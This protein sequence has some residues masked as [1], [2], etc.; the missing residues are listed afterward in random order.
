MLKGYSKRD[1]EFARRWFKK[2]K[3]VKVLGGKCSKCG[4]DNIVCLEFHHLDSKEKDFCVAKM[5]DRSAP[6]PEIEE[7][8]KKCI[9]LC[10][11]CH[12]EFH[13]RRDGMGEN[14][15]WISK[16]ELLKSIDKSS[17][18]ECG[19]NKSKACLT[20]HHEDA[21]EK[22]FSISKVMTS[23]SGFSIEDIYNEIDKCVIL[24]R[25]CHRIKHFD[26][27]RYARLK[28]Y[29]EH[30]MKTYK[31]R[32]EIDYG[33]IKVMVRKNMRH[34]EIARELG[35]CQTTVRCAINRMKKRGDL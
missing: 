15:G 21:N 3:A 4:N 2:T 22:R 24:C 35:C 20:F 25:N 19:Y 8:I 18:K 26:A 32:K 17:C 13:Y 5:L 11:N 1:N 33:K 29:I 9:L 6:W 12:Y 30:K 34:C 31:M 16:H 10:S 14:N 28:I 23:K 7:E 27:E